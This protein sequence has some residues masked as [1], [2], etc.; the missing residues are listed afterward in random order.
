ML[1]KETSKVY[2]RTFG[3][4]MNEHD[5]ER[6]Y[7]LLLNSGFIQAEGEEDADLLLLNTCTIRQ[8]AE[9]KAFSALGRLKAMKAERPGLKIGFCGCIAQ[10]EGHRVIRR[11][12]HVDLIFGTK[13]IH[14]LPYLL[15]KLYEKGNREVE[16]SNDNEFSKQ[17][18]CPVRRASPIKAWV[19]IMQGCNN[20]CTYCV[21]PYVRGREWSRSPE[22]IL[23]EI[24]DLVARGYKEV[25]LLGHNVNSYGQQEGWNFSFPTLLRA[26]EEIPGLERIR[27]TTSH[28]KDFSVELVEAIADCA[29]V[30]EHIHLPFQSGSDKILKG[31][32]RKYT[33]AEYLERVEV[34]RKRIPQAALTSDVIV[35]FPG[36]EEEDFQQT[37]HLIE[38]VQFDGLF[39][40]LYSIRPQ[41]AAGNFPEQVPNSIKQERFEILLSIQNEMSLKKNK[42]LLGT[43]QEVLV[44]EVLTEA[45]RRPDSRV[46][47]RGRT[48]LNKIVEFTGSANVVGS[49]QKVEIVQANRFNLK[50]VVC[51]KKA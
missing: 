41:T 7:G 8:K 47:L 6:M 51:S 15:N 25:T 38:S 42:A 49:F 40:F 13:N 50:G 30:C 31:M 11:A 9:Q 17:F 18:C 39:T 44:E 2:I 34:I 33:R 32:N 16:I 21:V 23:S 1:K 14:R 27:F 28:P 35:G 24:R 46:Q 29:K 12:P 20:Y 48:R 45:E 5:S 3:C 26:I 22:E 36:E 37:L 4:Q 10:R 43:Q 19:T